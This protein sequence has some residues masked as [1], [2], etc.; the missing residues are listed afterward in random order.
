MNVDKPTSMKE[1]VEMNKLMQSEKKIQNK[2]K[3]IANGNS[4]IRLKKSKKRFGKNKNM[5]QQRQKISD[6]L[7]K[8]FNIN[9]LPNNVTKMINNLKPGEALDMTTVTSRVKK[10]KNIANEIARGSAIV[11]TEAGLKKH[12]GVDKLPN[13]VGRLIQTLKPGEVLDLKLVENSMTKAKNE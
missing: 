10:T 11:K 2:T 7:K 3:K 8:Q 1:F 9:K 6:E 5:K 4:N 12:Y 13:D